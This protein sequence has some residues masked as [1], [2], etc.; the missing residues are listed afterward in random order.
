MADF[1]GVIR[2]TVDGLVNNTP[3]ARQKIYDRARQTIERQLEASPSEASAKIFN[4]QLEQVEAAIADIEK[5]FVGGKGKP[6]ATKKA[7]TGAKKPAAKTKAKSTAKEG[8]K[9]VVPPAAPLPD[10]VG[11]DDKEEAPAEEARIE[12]PRQPARKPFEAP[13]EGAKRAAPN[14][15]TIS[16]EPKELAVDPVADST[17]DP[18]VDPGLSNPVNDL[19]ERRRRLRAESQMNAELAIPKIAEPSMGAPAAD[20][21]ADHSDEPDEVLEAEDFDDNE[22]YADDDYEADDFEEDQEDFE[23]ADDH[24]DEDFD[25][26]DEDDAPSDG[27]DALTQGFDDDLLDD[28]EHVEEINFINEPSYEAKY[29]PDYGN[30]YPGDS[31]PNQFDDPVFPTSDSQY[32]YYDNQAA[33]NAPD[34]KDIIDEAV[35]EIRSNLEMSFSD[36]EEPAPQVQEDPFGFGEEALPETPLRPKRESKFPL[37]FVVGGISVIILLLIVVIFSFSGSDD[38]APVVATPTQDETVDEATPE[39][40]TAAAEVNDNVA[41]DGSEKFTQRLNPD[42]TE[43]EEGPAANAINGLPGEEGRSVAS[44]SGE[45]ETSLVVA[46]PSASGEGEAG[47]ILQKMF[48]YET[49]QDLDQQARYEGSVAWSEETETDG[50]SSRPFIQ[51]NIQVPERN[52]NVLMTIKLNGDETLPVSHLIDFNFALPIDFDG[53]EIEAVN[54]VTLK[55]AEA[56]PGNPLSAI[57]AKITDVVFVVGLENDSAEVVASNLQ[58]LS[59]RNWMDIPIT[60]SNGRKALITLEKGSAGSVIFDRVLAEWQR[61][62]AQ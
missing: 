50:T 60:Y 48:F 31:A 10:L 27:A 35:G 15:P 7:G 41:D 32:D 34:D 6:S 39:T 40:Q 30:D 1:V 13:V 22:E 24:A 55:D 29:E 25:E 62:P 14:K 43:V 51:A 38:T 56:Q 53:G 49:S 20:D 18:T 5:E 59:S 16:E 8:A 54:E 9:P 4:A 52:I 23:D 57:S 21:D 44:Q 36:I 19:A 2:R 12:E 47:A 42:G 61:N 17:V 3:E 45:V 33:G 58:L 26:S 37:M 28:I 11:G 46:D